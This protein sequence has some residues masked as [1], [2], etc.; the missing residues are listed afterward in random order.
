VPARPDEYR[1]FI[2]DQD[3]KVEGT[4]KVNARVAVRFK[5]DTEGK[6]HALRIIVRTE[7]KMTSGRGRTGTSQ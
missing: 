2:V 6:T 5:V 3:T 7:A 4:L 1:Q